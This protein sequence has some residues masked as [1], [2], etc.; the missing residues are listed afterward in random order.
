[1]FLTPAGSDVVLFVFMPQKFGDLPFPLHISSSIFPWLESLFLRTFAVSCEFSINHDNYCRNLFEFSCGRYKCSF[2]KSAM[3]QGKFTKT[4]ANFRRN[5]LSLLLHSTV[6]QLEVGKWMLYEWSPRMTS[7][8][9]LRLRSFG[10]VLW[11][12]NGLHYSDFSQ[13]WKFIK[14]CG[15]NQKQNFFWNYDQECI[16]IVLGVVGT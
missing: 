1:M 16:D 15:F 10:L 9:A 12:D 7:R 2:K 14:N 4:K 5:S 13:L 8:N 3:F 11:L 6:Q